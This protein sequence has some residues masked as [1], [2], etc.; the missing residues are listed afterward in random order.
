MKVTRN[1]TDKSISNPGLL[2]LNNINVATLGQLNSLLQA[3]GVTISYGGVDDLGKRLIVSE[4]DAVDWTL[5][6]NGTLFGG[7]YQAV[8]VA[9][10]AAAGNV[11]V[12]K[13]AFFNNAAGSAA[14]FV[15]TDESVAD[16]NG[17]VAGIFIN[18]ITPGN[19][20]FIQVAGKVNVL[21]KNPITNGAPAVGDALFSG[22]GSGTVDDLTLASVFSTAFLNRYL[23]FAI[24]LPASNTTI[25]M[26]LRPIFTR[27]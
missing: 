21:L 24:A 9:A 23:G 14:G 10:T 11:A 16:N 5:A 3:A 7:M 13:V 22:G 26:Q 18:T 4:A 8:Q 20:G 15:V 2:Q 17:E 6:A 27:F 19:F 1:F 25:A 12:G